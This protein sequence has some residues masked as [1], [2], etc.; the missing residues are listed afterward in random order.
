MK[1]MNWLLS[2]WK[3]RQKPKIKCSFCEEIID[4]S[5]EP[6]MI[7][8][9]T[10]EGMSVFTICDSCTETFEEFRKFVE[11]EVTRRRDI[12]EDDEPIRRDKKLH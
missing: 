9:K 6:F 1:L 11:E 10:L 12:G 3:A 4:S 7:E 2:R 5:T 8:M